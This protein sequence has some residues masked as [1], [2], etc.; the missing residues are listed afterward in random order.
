MKWNYRIIKKDDRYFLAEVFYKNGKP[1]SWSEPI[2][3]GEDVS[4]I[5]KTIELM[6]YDLRYKPLEVKGNKL[7]E[8]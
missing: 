3:N 1:H 6:N 4:D 8:L 7:K 5:Q 2:M